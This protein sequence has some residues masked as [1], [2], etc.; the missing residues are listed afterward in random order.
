MTNQFEIWPRNYIWP[1]YAN[2]AE[3]Q[4]T[5]RKFMAE[6]EAKNNTKT[7]IRIAHLNSRPRDDVKYM[8]YIVT[9]RIMCTNEFYV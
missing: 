3:K 6:Q 1:W 5:N 8:F 7:W 2:I 9:L 4:R